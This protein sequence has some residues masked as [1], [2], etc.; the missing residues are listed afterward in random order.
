VIL[1]SESGGPLRRHRQ[2][3]D[4]QPWRNYLQLTTDDSQTAADDIIDHNSNGALRTH[5][6]PLQ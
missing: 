6:T 2:S 4:L 3:A 1:S 5:Q